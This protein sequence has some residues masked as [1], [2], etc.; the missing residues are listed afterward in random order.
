MDEADRAQFEIE[1]SLQ[2]AIRSR[3]PVDQP[4]TGCCYWCESEISIG[5]FCDADCRDDYE[6]DAAARARAGRQA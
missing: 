5:A 2:Q 3:K 4:F 6:R 1:R